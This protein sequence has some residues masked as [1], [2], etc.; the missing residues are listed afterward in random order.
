MPRTCENFL[1]LCE[2]PEGQGFKGSSV[3][4]VRRTMGI[5]MGD[6][7]RGDGRG[8]RAAI[9]PS[10]TFADE[11]FVGRHSQ[12]GTVSMCNHG[13]DTNNSVFFIANRPMPHLDGRH[14]LFATVVSG[15]E[16]I[17]TLSQAFSVNFRP[18]DAIRIVDCGEVVRS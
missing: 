14:V 13:V 8:G 5:E 17:A 2:R 16:H 6:F 9:D 1:T 3:H 7:V 11:S 12:A 18:V 4:R 10:G 15:L